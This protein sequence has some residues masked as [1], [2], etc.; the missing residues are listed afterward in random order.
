MWIFS[1]SANQASLA[2][3]YGA[4]VIVWAPPL[5]LFA[6]V[7][8]GWA[9]RFWVEGLFASSIVT[10]AKRRYGKARALAGADNMPAAKRA[11]LD[12]FKEAPGVPD[13]LFEAARMLVQKRRF[14][15]AVFFYD[16][17][18]KRFAADSAVWGKAAW[19]LSVV[20]EEGLRRPKEA[21]RLRRDIMNRMPRSEAGK[22]A[23][24]AA[25]GRRAA[26]A[27]RGLSRRKFPR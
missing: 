16:I 11:Y 12:A 8:G 23:I 27:R 13:P 22:M 18:M 14:A 2:A 9:A 5:Y 6:Q 26:A 20:Y 24:A 1:T 19:Q 25:R 17:L 4:A 10:P 3:A 15:E 7:F 21:E